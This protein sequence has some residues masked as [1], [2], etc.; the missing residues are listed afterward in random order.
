MAGS[1]KDN[2]NEWKERLENFDAGLLSNLEGSWNKLEK[3]RVIIKSNARRKYLG[4]AAAVLAI[5]FVSGLV[6]TN[7]STDT[8]DAGESSIKNPLPVVTKPTEQTVTT[9]KND[10][11]S[12]NKKNIVNLKPAKVSGK[13]NFSAEKLQAPPVVALPESTN[14]NEVVASL[15]ISINDSSPPNEIT[16]RPVKKMRVIHLNELSAKPT[17]DNISKQEGRPYFPV[18]FQ[19]R[20]VYTN[21]AGQQSKKDNSNLIR[22]KLV[23]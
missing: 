14:L 17:E 19:S 11:Y 4:M 18:T 10:E 12:K 23:P 7:R 22:I 3:K 1:N 20:Q 2:K 16:V 8:A 13:K 6:I 9:V 5:V 21:S 15:N